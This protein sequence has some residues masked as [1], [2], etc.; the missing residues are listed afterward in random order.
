VAATS[1]LQSA[2]AAGHP[3]FACYLSAE[4]AQETTKSNRPTQPRPLWLE[5][6]IDLDGLAS[7]NLHRFKMAARTSRQ[8][9]HPRVGHLLSK[10]FTDAWETQDF[11]WR[12]PW[13][14]PFD[15]LELKLEATLRGL[16]NCPGDR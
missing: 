13:P 8:T 9:R 6:V 5:W 12:A 1:P 4:I 3:A 7:E 16:E 15:F 14:A 10:K 2:T 11:A